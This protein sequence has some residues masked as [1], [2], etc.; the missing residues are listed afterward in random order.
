MTLLY[1]IIGFCTLFLL[2]N[3]LCLG[4]IESRL[5]IGKT[6][7][8]FVRYGYLGISMKVI[9][10]NDTERWLFKEPTYNVFRVSVYLLCILHVIC[11]WSFTDCRHEYVSRKKNELFQPAKK[12]IIDV[13]QKK[14]GGFF[15]NKINQIELF[16][17]CWWF[18]SQ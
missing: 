3:K 7:N 1:K 5:R 8:V 17:C 13:N 11:H 9:S 16:R 6:I 12:K 4:K 14:E 2:I 18:F 10:Y 15:S